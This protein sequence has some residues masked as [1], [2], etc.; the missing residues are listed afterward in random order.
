M[1]QELALEK[2]FEWFNSQVSSSFS[3]NRNSASKQIRSINDKVEELKSSAHRFDYSDIK[4][5]DVYQNYA[6]TIFI[7]TNELFE[8]IEIP[9]NITYNNL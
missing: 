2:A 9:E 3:G 4:D 6:T 7:K 5:P 1:S 8:D